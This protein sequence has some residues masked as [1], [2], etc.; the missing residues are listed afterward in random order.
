MQIQVQLN[1]ADIETAIKDYL[2]KVGM[3]S[4]VDTINFTTSGGKGKQTVSASID[5]SA[6]GMTLNTPPVEEPAPK[7]EPKSEKKEPEPTPTEPPFEP[8]AQEESANDSTEAEPTTE[9]KSLFG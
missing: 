9:S 4:Q 8:D 5:L 6:G 1:Q 7:A 3:T 2:A